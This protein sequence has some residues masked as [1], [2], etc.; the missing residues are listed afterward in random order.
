MTS[1]A[2]LCQPNCRISEFKKITKLRVNLTPDIDK[3]KKG[4]NAK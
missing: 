2:F 1:D 4:L 3:D